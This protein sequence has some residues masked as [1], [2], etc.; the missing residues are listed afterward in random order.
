VVWNSVYSIGWCV[1]FK[2]RIPCP[3]L[4]KKE[5]GFFQENLLKEKK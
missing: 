1:A 3:V 5:I 2:R 4:N